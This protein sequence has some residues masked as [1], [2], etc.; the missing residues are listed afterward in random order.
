MEGRA[1][2]AGRKIPL[3][4]GTHQRL[5]AVPPPAWPRP[6]PGGLRSSLQRKLDA[7]GARRK[8]CPLP[9]GPS[10]GGAG[11]ETRCKTL[12]TWQRSCRPRCWYG[13]AP[14]TAPA[15]SEHGGAS[16]EY[17]SL[18]LGGCLSWSGPLV[19]CP[20]HIWP[21]TGLWH[22][23]T[24]SHPPCGWPGSWSCWQHPWK[25]SQRHS[26]SSSGT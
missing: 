22:T 5:V 1:C 15:T 10:R 26:P 17:G 24:H 11:Q 8:P 4:S 2:Y 14:E 16:A 23:G 13:G 18:T 9:Y 20:A 25:W 7:P 3:W 6:A 12:S 21:L 19:R